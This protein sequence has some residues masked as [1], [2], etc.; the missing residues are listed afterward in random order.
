[1][2]PTRGSY[3]PL[4]LQRTFNEAFKRHQLGLGIEK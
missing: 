2:F 3:G 1:M 4:M